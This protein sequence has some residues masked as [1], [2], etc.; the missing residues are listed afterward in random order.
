MAAVVTAAAA[1]VVAV[2]VV[3]ATAVAVRAAATRG[4]VVLAGDRNSR[5]HTKGRGPRRVNT[6]TRTT[7]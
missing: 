6:A 7:P 5:P 4:A 1:L 2:T 3:A